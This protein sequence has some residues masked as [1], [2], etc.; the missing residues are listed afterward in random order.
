MIS[1]DGVESVDLQGATVSSYTWNGLSPNT[2]YWFYVA[3]KIYGTP[4]DPTGSG[5]TQS[6]W[7]GPVYAI[8]V[9]TQPL[10]SPAQQPLT[11]GPGVQ[12]AGA[13]GYGA[14]AWSEGDMLNSVKSGLGDTQAQAEAATVQACK[15]GGVDCRLRAMLCAGMVRNAYSSF[16]P[17]S[18]GTLWG[19]GYAGSSAEG[20]LVCA[21]RL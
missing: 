15:A 18:S 16:A 17:D 13:Q 2:K 14:W 6:A 9:G 3:S 8:T 7:V 1:R 21:I 5:N 10:T 11:A 19:F 4:G 20:G 12:S